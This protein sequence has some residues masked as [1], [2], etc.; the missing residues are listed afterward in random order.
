MST[1][2]PLTAVRLRELLDYNPETG[3]FTWLTTRG[4]RAV[5]GTVAGGSHSK[6]YRQ[7]GVGGKHYLS[8]RLAWLYTHGAWP[9]F[10]I[11]H[12]DEV[13]TN[14]RISNLRDVTSV[15]NQHNRNRPHRDNTS[16]FVGVDWRQASHK[17]RA[18]IKAYGVYKHLGYFATAE[19]ASEAYLT[20]KRAYHA[21][22]TLSQSTKELL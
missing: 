12:K 8:H 20:A 2:A 10:E 16:G 11:D 3:I 6:G 18:R 14:N 21:G 7:I 13:K 4:S 9:T 19:L 17:F 22:C 15:V 5:A 1:S